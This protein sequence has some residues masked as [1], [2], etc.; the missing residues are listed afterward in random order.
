MVG[1]DGATRIHIDAGHEF[2]RRVFRQLLHDVD[3]LVVFALGGDDVNGFVFIDENTLVADLSAHFTVERCVVEHEFV[4]FV[5]LLRHFSVTKNVAGVFGV[6]VTDEL[7]FAGHQ[8]RP[9]AIFDL[10]RIAGA[11]FLLLHLGVE[12][13][14]IHRESVFAADELREVEGEAIGVEEAESHGSVEDFRRFVLAPTHLRTFAASNFFLQQLNTLVERAQEGIFLFF[15]D[16]G[17]ELLL[18]FEFGEGI[19][20]FIDEHG[21]EFI[22]KRIFLTQERVGIAHGTT[23]DATNHVACLGVARQLAVGNREGDGPEV[24]GADAHGNVNLL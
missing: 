2:R 11:V 13:G 19:A 17:N 20:H 23:Q 21:Q 24:V 10:C 6:V 22:E 16:A 18:R 8:F 15:D 1:L 12:L 7:L 4:V 3:A 14:L 5:F 9:V